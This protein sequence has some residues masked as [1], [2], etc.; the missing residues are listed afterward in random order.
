MC[1]ARL[2]RRYVAD[3]RDGADSPFEFILT[4]AGE[5]FKGKIPLSFLGDLLQNFHGDERGAWSKCDLN[6]LPILI[7]FQAF[8]AEVE[9]DDWFNLGRAYPVVS[10]V[11]NL[12]HRWH[13]LQVFALWNQRSRRP[14]ESVG[15]AK[16]VFELTKFPQQY[17]DLLSFYP[18]VL[19]Y[20]PKVN[21]AIGSRGVWI[22]GVC[23]TSFRTEDEVTMQRGAGG[24]EL[25]VGT[26][27]IRCAENPRA[28]LDEIRRWLGWYFQEFVP[29]VSDLAR[30]MPESRHRMWQLDKIACPEC[31]RLLVPCAGDLGVALK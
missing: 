11:L 15:E 3:M 17:E 23:V 7:A 26:L 6:R 13:W 12:E 10:A 9:I 27:R 4:L 5:C 20:A 28:A 24:F 2:S 1:L 30:P 31:S 8:L 21:L 18:D 29:S 19:L 16:T 14:W 22:E 25:Q